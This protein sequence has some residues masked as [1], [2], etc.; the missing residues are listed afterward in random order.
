MDMRPWN[1]NLTQLSLQIKKGN[2][3]A[4]RT[5]KEATSFT[6]FLPAYLWLVVS[7]RRAT[8]EHLSTRQRRTC[9]HLV[10]GAQD[11]RAGLLFFCP[12]N[13]TSCRQQLECILDS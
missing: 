12:T 2:D 6:G 9:I 7:R 13:Q 1:K 5:T 3:F 8:Y 11:V 10:V 4:T